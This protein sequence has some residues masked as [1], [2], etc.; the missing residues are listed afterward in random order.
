MIVKLNCKDN[1][2][3]HY[4]T[5]H[6]SA[7]GTAPPTSPHAPEH[8]LEHAVAQMS[9]DVPEGAKADKA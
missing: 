2:V 7:G 5:E 8:A 1:N 6:S 3:M 9:I 4:G